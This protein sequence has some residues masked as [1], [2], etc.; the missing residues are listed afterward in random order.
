MKEEDAFKLAEQI[1]NYVNTWD[2]SGVAELFNKAM[3]REHPTLQQSF[4]R[5]CLAWL[6]FVASPDYHTDARNEDSK[7]V[8]TDLMELFQTYIYNTYGT[9]AN[10]SPVVWIGMV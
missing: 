3:S 7:T 8:A 5:L 9:G 6:E 10:P 2:H 4:T 1:T